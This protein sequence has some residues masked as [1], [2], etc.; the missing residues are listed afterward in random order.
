[1]VLGIGTGTA[2]GIAGGLFHMLNNAIYKS[3][4]FLCAGSVEKQA[5]HD[6]P[7]PAG[8]PGPVDAGDL[9]RLPGGGA[10]HLRHP[11]AQ[12]VRLQVDGLPG[13][14]RRGGPGGALLGHLA[15]GGDAGL[16]PDPGQFREGAARRVPAQARRGPAGR[17]REAGAGMWLPTVAALGALRPLR[18]VLA[19]RLPV[20]AVPGAP[21][22]RGRRVRAGRLVG[23]PRD[24]AARV[25]ARR[26]AAAVRALERAARRARA[27][28]TS[29]ANGST[30]RTSA[31]RPASAARDVEVTGVGLLP[32]GARNWRRCGG[33]TGPRSAR[34]STSTTWGREPC[35]TSSSCC[36]A[37]TRAGCPPT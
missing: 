16:R 32:H 34:C 12:R 20:E 35:S 1:M 19:Y 7:G 37:P 17:L 23:R 31:G 26:R 30:T 24:A 15:G 11:A 33:S 36:A 25:R 4:L 5:G 13:R 3:C 9:R 22:R 18:R 21:G 6:R 14:H 8:R 27:R 29:A 10:G 2:V 28:R